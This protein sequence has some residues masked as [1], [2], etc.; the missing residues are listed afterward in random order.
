MVGFW[1]LE[2]APDWK[3]RE[4]GELGVGEMTKEKKNC[5]IKWCTDGVSDLQGQNSLYGPNWSILECL[6]PSWY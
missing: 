3:D 2:K 1:F 4:K 6:G 5:L